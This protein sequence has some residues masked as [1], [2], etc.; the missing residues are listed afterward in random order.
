M[1][2]LVT[3]HGEWQVMFDA[4]AIV[5]INGSAMFAVVRQAIDLLCTSHLPVSQ[6]APA[7]V[8][9]DAG[10]LSRYLWDKGFTGAIPKLASRWQSRWLSREI[11]RRS[12]SLDWVR[13]ILGEE[14]KDF[15]ALRLD[16]AQA[17]GEV[18]FNII[19]ALGKVLMTQPDLL[20]ADTHLASGQC[21]LPEAH[22]IDSS[23][24]RPEAPKP[25]PKLGE[26]GFWQLNP[27]RSWL[28][29]DREPGLAL[30]LEALAQLPQ[31][32]KLQVDHLKPAEL[33]VLMRAIAGTP[34]LRVLAL[35]AL[36]MR[37][38]DGQWST[39]P[40]TDA[41]RAALQ[42]AWENCT[43]I[44]SLRMNWFSQGMLAA[45]LAAASHLKRLSIQGKID[46]LNRERFLTIR[47]AH[48]KEL[49]LSHADVGIDFIRALKPELLPQLKRVGVLVGGS[50]E[51]ARD[52]DDSAV[53]H[54]VELKSDHEVQRSYLPDRSWTV[55]RWFSDTW[56]GPT[57][58]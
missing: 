43:H 31:L 55:G 54:Y 13:K 12:M 22:E 26:P 42:A 48:L 18:T 35:D 9:F 24:L 44:D 11:L 17:N 23:V 56:V 49:D 37:I 6:R 50:V 19:P 7:E 5:E 29:I 34:R 28:R 53:S 58:D 33:P 47:F 41:D 2:G 16:F 27:A 30:A 39:E 25:I 21:A 4:L 14:R 46:A 10:A 52:W 32:S 45:I 40:E 51:V 36:N 1:S 15:A 57:R 20:V 8:S 38:V 3:F